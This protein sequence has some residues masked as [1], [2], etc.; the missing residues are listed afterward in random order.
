MRR[1]LATILAVLLSCLTL[2]TAQ[3]QQEP[4]TIYELVYAFDF[5]FSQ[6]LTPEEYEAYQS[7]NPEEI[8]AESPELYE[9]IRQNVKRWT[10]EWIR[11]A[12]KKYEKLPRERL[13]DALQS[14]SRVDGVLEPYFEAREW[15]Y[16][17]I[18]AVFLPQRLFHDERNRGLQTSGMFIPF[19][20]EVFFATVNPNLPLD[21]I[22]M[23]ETVHFNQE[24]VWMGR[25]LVEGI[26]ET[27]ARDLATKNGLVTGKQS[28]N[29]ATY[30]RERKLVDF[31]I[32]KIVERTEGDRESALD[33]LL[34]AYVTGDHSRIKNVLGEE[35]W[36]R[37]LNTSRTARAW[38]MVT[39]GV[40]E[41]LN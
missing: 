22:F 33:I 7:K 30:A 3:G 40:R 10:D 8:R 2:T 16:R 4:E 18:N 23:H 31:I 24:G 20:P 38:H 17:T 1:A 9:K 12:V 34:E 29:Y 13:D 39:R 37:V 35:A 15:P 14:I 11:D 32:D 19:Y 36:D 26:T 21:L 41:A 27:V 5:T 6:I 28:R 25:A